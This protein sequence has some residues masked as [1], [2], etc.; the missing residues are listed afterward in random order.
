MIMAGKSYGKL[1]RASIAVV[2]CLCLLLFAWY[3]MTK[4]DVYDTITV[5][6]DDFPDILITPEGAESVTFLSPSNSDIVKGNYHLWFLIKDSYPAEQTR[7]FIEKHLSSKCWQPLNYS[8]L[9]P[10]LPMHVEWVQ[11]TESGEEAEIKEW[12]QD[13]LGTKGESIKVILQYRSIPGNEQEPD[14]LWVSLLFAESNERQRLWVMKYKDLHPE[15][16]QEITDV[17]KPNVQK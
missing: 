7:K 14:S 10:H 6:P 8:L 15:E 12:M 17:S 3:L 11:Y 16:F 4:R 9:N 1:I 13:W 5:R 2:V